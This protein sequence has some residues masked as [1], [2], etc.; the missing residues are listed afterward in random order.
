METIAWTGGLRLR[1][2]LGRFDAVWLLVTG[3]VAIDTIGA[4]ASGGA[5]A[6]TWLAVVAA[7]FFVPAALVVAELG[8]AFP[9][10]GAP[11]VWV[12]LAFG[13]L[14]G[15]LS[16]FCYWIEAP[17]WLGGSLAITAVTVTNEFVVPLHGAV[18]VEVAL[19]FVWTA[20]LAAVMPISKGRWVTA[21]GAITQFALLGLFTGTV[22][23]Y[24][25]A[26]GLHGVSATGFMPA[27]GGLVVV[28]PVLVYCFLG[29]ELPSS[30]AGEMR[31]ARRDV[32]AAIW[33]AGI[34][35][36]L[37]YGVP[38]LAILVVLPTGRIT[39]LG[40][41]IDAMKAVFTVYGGY[42]TADGRHVLTGAGSILGTLAAASF[43]LVL[44]T[45]GLAWVMSS[46]RS[47]AVACLDG[48]GPQRLGRFSPRTGT[49]VAML[50]LSGV[51]A[52]VTS[53]TAFAITGD[54][55]DRYFGIVLA[56]SIALLA[57]ANV[58]VFPALVRLRRS[59]PDVPRPFRVP[60]GVAGARAA[61][62]LATAWCLL[63]A[64]VVLVPG[65]PSSS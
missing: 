40:G 14:V 45:N 55:G 26:H 63:A 29:F 23:V 52:T 34:L 62:G 17:V 6:L 9:M 4:V 7:L 16:S 35:T 24:A 25:L 59:M 31:D 51:V 44:L 36:V 56:L 13:R 15:A 32:P 18:R 11:Y 10:E 57:L 1:R 47:Q 48:A 54:D 53:A 27:W 43:L 3:I 20:I 33:R 61:S 39:G 64:V 50:L 60:G 37:M 19:A 58:A 49:P 41:F 5:E 38:T 30:A 65:M 12:A 22:V 42:E 46:A 2:E 28:A 8:S 21:T